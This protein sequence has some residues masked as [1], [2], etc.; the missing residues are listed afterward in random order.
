MA[1]AKTLVFMAV[2]V[3]AANLSWAA[4]CAE[5]SYLSSCSKCSFDNVSGKMD[6]ACY[7]GYQSRGSACLVAAYPAAATMYQLGSCPAIQTCIDRLQEC[8]ALYTDG[9][10]KNDCLSG[11]IDHCFEKGDACVAAAAADCN[12]DPSDALANVAPPASFCD[13]FFFAILFPF[14][15]A[16]FLQIKK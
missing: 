8:K 14:A 10:D 3:L 1:I 9:N 6:Q 5:K 15:G 7:E 12:K 4:T 11:S 16:A 13:S 2:L